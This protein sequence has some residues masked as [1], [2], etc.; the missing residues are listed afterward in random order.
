MCLLTHTQT[1]THTHCIY[2]L[3]TYLR[4]NSDFYPIL[5]ELNGDEK[6]LLRG[7]NWVF[8][9]SSLRFVFKDLICGLVQA[10][11]SGNV[12]NF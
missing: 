6:C 5:H 12:I 3:C 11:F 10:L 2:V 8:K 9:K 7:T 4:A 1:H